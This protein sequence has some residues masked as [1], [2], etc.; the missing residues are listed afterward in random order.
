[1]AWGDGEAE[2]V[3]QVAGVAVGD[4]AGQAGHLGVEHLLGGD[5]LVQVGQLAAVGGGLGAL[6]Q[7]AAHQLAGE[8]DLDTDAGLGQLVVGGGDQVVEGAVEVGERDVDAHAGD[9]E[10]LGGRPF[11]ACPLGR[12]HGTFCPPGTTNPRTRRRRGHSVD[13]SGAAA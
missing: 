1:V 11:H 13:W 5:D 9:R 4:G 10:P 7:V 3:A 12:H 8:A 2:D 6:Q